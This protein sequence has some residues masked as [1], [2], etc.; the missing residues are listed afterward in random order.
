M[1][2]NGKGTR[3]SDYWAFLVV[4][5]VNLWLLWTAGMLARRFGPENPARA[6]WAVHRRRAACRKAG[7]PGVMPPSPCM[8]SSST[9]QVA[10][11]FGR[12]LLDDLTWRLAPGERVGLVGVNG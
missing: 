12:V 1:A 11:Y 8:G 4:L 10:Q 5:T 6:P 2:S 7:V 9:A 3:A